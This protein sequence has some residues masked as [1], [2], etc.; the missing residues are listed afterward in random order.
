MSFL[1]VINAR[2]KVAANEHNIQPVTEAVPNSLFLHVEASL[3]GGVRE[4][5][6][7]EMPYDSNTAN[8]E[9]T[10]RQ[11]WLAKIDAVYGPLL[12][13]C[14]VG[15][16]D[17]GKRREIWHDLT[18]KRLFPLGSKVYSIIPIKFQNTPFCL[19]YYCGGDGKILPSKFY[20]MQ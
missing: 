9:E 4:G 1:E 7:V 12:K 3:D 18:K 8:N 2:R 5:M 20:N 19:K 17:E 11:F 14:Y 6:I 15:Y 13:L 16:K 10:C